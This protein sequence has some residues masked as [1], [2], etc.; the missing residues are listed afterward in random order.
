MDRPQ[1][2]LLDILLGF[3]EAL[4]LVDH[5]VANHHMQ[6]AYIAYSIADKL[7]YSHEDKRQIVMAG[8]LHD[9]GAISIQERLL[10]LKF[11]DYLTHKH[12]EVGYLFLRQFAPLQFAAEIIRYHHVPWMGGKGRKVFNFEVPEESHIIHLADRIAVLIKNPA[13]ILEEKENICSKI[14]HYRGIAFVPEHVDAFL[15]LAECEYFWLDVV[16]NQIPLILKRY[17][18]PAVID[19]SLN[20]LQDFARLFSRIVDF[21]SPLNASHSSGVA[22]IA[23]RLAEKAG[24]SDTECKLMR[25]AGYLH[26]LGK[27]AV[28]VEILEKPGKLSPQ[29][30][31]VI[32]RH[33]YYT[34]SILSKIESL[35]II[36]KWASFHHERLDGRGY[37]FHLKE[38]DLPIGSQIM[39]VA[40]VFTAVCEDRPYRQGMN[41]KEVLGILEK[42]ALDKAINGD[43]VNFIKDDFDMLNDERKSMQKESLRDYEHIVHPLKGLK[44]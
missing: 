42:M 27:I 5:A 14:K 22:L 32:K 33:P 2:E 7:G 9:I 12:A 15:E 25:V 10:A 3:S 35:T 38:K 11:E 18:S 34:Y 6:V 36:N 24:F 21:R 43:I 1:V 13:C 26:D 17:L 8:A 20:Q 31:L 16:S 44:L 30:F 37:P 4:D 23:E 28:P 29:E 39:A 40:D 41:K 19:L